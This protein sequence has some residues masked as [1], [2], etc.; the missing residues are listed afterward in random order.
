MGSHRKAYDQ[1]PGGI[2]V[3]YVEV[4]LEASSDGELNPPVRLYD[5]S[6]PG[7]EPTVGLPAHPGGLDRRAGRCGHRPGPSLPAPRR[8]AG[9]VAR[10][11]CGSGGALAGPTRSLCHPDALR[12]ARPDH[13]GDGLRGHPGR[14][15]GRLHPL[16]TP[17]PPTSTSLTARMQRGYSTRSAWT[18]SKTT[19]SSS[20]ATAT[21]PPSSSPAA[22]SCAT[23]ET[24]DSR[25]SEV[26]A[27]G[28][29]FVPPQVGQS[30]PGKELETVGQQVST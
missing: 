12:P 16:P 7:S 9:P 13:P 10:R 22:G 25:A 23:G 21:A 28:R 29:G 30:L 19:A 1:M 11:R 2:R 15:Q 26:A 8:R 6:E 24:P 20:S 17:T 14:A 4:V 18:R 3:P 5:T 27:V